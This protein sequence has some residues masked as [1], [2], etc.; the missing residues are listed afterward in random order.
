MQ[1]MSEQVERAPQPA[2]TRTAFGWLRSCLSRSN[3]RRNQL[4][5]ALRRLPP[6]RSECPAT[7]CA[8]SRSNE[9]RNQLPLAL[10]RAA[11]AAERPGA[12]LSR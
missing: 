9:G 12:C 2:P 10:R 4:P 1:R 3:E 5:L 6:L 8:A 7:G 11:S